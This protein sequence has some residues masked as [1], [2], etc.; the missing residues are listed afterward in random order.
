VRATG[1][2]NLSIL[3]G[4]MRDLRSSG[5]ADLAAEITGPLDKPVFSGEANVAG[6]RVRH[7]S[8][9]HAL[10]AINGKISFDATGLRMDGLTARLG[11]GL[12][13]FG[14]RIAMNGY[15]PGEF[16]LTASGEGMRLRYPEGFRSLVDADLSLRGP[17]D[18]PTLGGTVTVRSSVWERRFETSINLLE[19]VGRTTPVGPPAAT[20]SFPLHFDVRLVAPSSLRIDNNVARIVSSADLAL[21][22]TYDRPLVFGRADI[23]RGEVTFE[24]KRYVVTHGTIDFSNPSRIEPFVDVEAQTHVRVPGQNYV[25]T[26]N[27]TGT[28]ARMSWSVNADPPLPTVDV[29]SLLLSDTAPTDPEL[30]ALE[31]PDAAKQQLLQARAAQLLVS[32]ISSEVTRVVEQ[33][34]AIDTFQITPSLVDPA[35]QS[36]RLVPGARLTIGK[37]ISNRVYLTFSQSLSASSTTRDQVILLEYDQNERLSWVLSQNEDR[38]YALDVRVRHAF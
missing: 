5:Q 32:P 35:A 10:E 27:A 21:R 7:F 9:P 11:G 4:F 22:G 34:F 16:N 1:D 26:L 3:Q 6:G 8:L 36:A 37:R 20:T 23:E 14:G 2:A 19:F 12:V 28:F 17:F 33:T 38:T 25:V 15:R 30:A 24:G 29:L 18:E 31:R 13:R